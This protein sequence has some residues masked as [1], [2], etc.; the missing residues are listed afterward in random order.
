[1]LPRLALLAVL[2]FAGCSPAAR[3]VRLD[4]APVFE[5]GFQVFPSPRTFDGPGTIFRIDANNVRRP[6]ADLGSML[7]LS[8][9]PEAVPSLIVSGTVD[10]NALLSWL[11]RGNAGGRIS[12]VDSAQVEV[13]GARRER[14]YESQ[15]RRL[16]D[17]AER[18]IDWTKPG[19]IFIITETVSADSVLFRI[20]QSAAAAVGDSLKSE[21]AT[22]RGVSFSWQPRRAASLA[23]R[24]PRPYRVFYKTDVLVRRSSLEP[25]SLP[26]I[27][28]VRENV[29]WLE[30]PEH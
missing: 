26:R 12:R 7:E 8:S 19:R 27:A 4:A 17:S 22:G 13:F 10:L 11:D 18:L 6:I 25:D 24:F 30:L 29:I 2:V 28:R 16:I 21:N 20:N 9:E 3:A 5:E 14:M 15:S 23:V 1:M